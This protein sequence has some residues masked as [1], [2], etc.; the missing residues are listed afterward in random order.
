MNRL[1]RSVKVTEDSPQVQDFS[2]PALLYSA[3]ADRASWLEG[4]VSFFQWVS[5]SCANT[6]TSAHSHTTNH[7]VPYWEMGD[8][9]RR[10]RS[11]E[12]LQAWPQA[13]PGKNQPKKVTSELN[14]SAMVIR[15][16]LHSSQHTHTH[17]SQA[18]PHLPI[19]LAWGACG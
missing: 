8:G 14:T 7:R 6:R 5:I 10:L 12:S 2:K 11:H 19:K 17:T 16:C 1:Y 18:W 4:C 13:S 15:M 3:C 9:D